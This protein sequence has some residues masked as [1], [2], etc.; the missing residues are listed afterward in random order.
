MPVATRPEKSIRWC[1]AFPFP[2]SSARTSRTLRARSDACSP[3]SCGNKGSEDSTSGKLRFPSHSL[4]GGS[5]RFERSECGN[6]QQRRL[7]PS[8]PCEL[9]NPTH[10][11]ASPHQRT[12]PGGRRALSE[13]PRPGGPR[14]RSRASGG[15]ECHRDPGGFGRL[16]LTIPAGGSL[17]GIPI[18]AT[19][20]LIESGRRHHSA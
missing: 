10:L 1:G 17:I 9:S 13:H 16:L 12:R 19:R 11:R 14:H 6:P 3:S 15:V 5:H 18:P 8:R 7:G 20:R 4:P 2:I